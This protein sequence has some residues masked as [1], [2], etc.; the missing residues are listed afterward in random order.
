MIGK[1]SNEDFKTWLEKYKI[2]GKNCFNNK[3]NKR[4]PFKFYQAGCRRI[5]QY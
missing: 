4:L 2:Y 1:I 5:F 3:S